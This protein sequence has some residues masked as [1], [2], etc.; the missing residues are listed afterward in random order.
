MFIIKRVYRVV[1]LS[2]ELTTVHALQ[3][4]SFFEEN[5]SASPNTLLYTVR[6]V[7][8][9]IVLRSNRLSRKC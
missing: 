9:V 5:T 1:S 7:F 8:Q 2:F 3:N 6:I 4:K